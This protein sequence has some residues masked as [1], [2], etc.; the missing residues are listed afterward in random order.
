MSMF[1]YTIRKRDKG[2]KFDCFKNRFYSSWNN[3]K[4][5]KR[6]E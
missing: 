2:I 5:E 4:K 1:I 6:Y 3:L